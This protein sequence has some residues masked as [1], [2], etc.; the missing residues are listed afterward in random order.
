MSDSDSDSDSDGRVDQSS[1]NT[2]NDSANRRLERIRTLTM[3]DF[4][5]AGM[6]AV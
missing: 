4:Q 1:N 3:T 5:Q 6:P 2:K